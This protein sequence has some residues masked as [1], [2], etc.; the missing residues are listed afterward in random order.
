MQGTRGGH[1][2]GART[3]RPSAGGG[4]AMDASRVGVP[5]DP[6]FPHG[7]WYGRPFT[8]HGTLFFFFFSAD[9]IH[10]GRVKEGAADAHV[11]AGEEGVDDARQRDGTAQAARA[12]VQGLRSSV[13]S[14]AALAV[15]LDR[16]RVPLILS[17]CRF[18]PWRG[19]GVV[20]HVY[21]M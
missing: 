20:R 13:P 6:P 18:L 11:T 1:M 12:W 2:D 21:Y 16:G 19:G 5:S 3:R 15:G 14:R 9:G 7:G 17:P 8:L 4:R 10:S